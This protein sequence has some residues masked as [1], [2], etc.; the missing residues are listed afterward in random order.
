[1]LLVFKSLWIFLYF[2]L[3]LLLNHTKYASYICVTKRFELF[4]IFFLYYYYIIIICYY[5]K[6]F[7]YCHYYIKNKYTAEIV[8]NMFFS[9]TAMLNTI[10]IY[11]YFIYNLE[12]G[13]LRFSNKMKV[14][15]FPLIMICFYI[16]NIN[17]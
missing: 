16:V 12:S 8:E 1:M 9:M 15:V 7:H 5:N 14:F 3:L 11:F 6:L 13:G 2:K 17:S 4:Q 10:N